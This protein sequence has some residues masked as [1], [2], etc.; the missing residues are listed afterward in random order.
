LTVV[1]PG[2]PNMN[3]NDLPEGTLE[4]REYEVSLNGESGSIALTLGKPDAD[5]ML[6]QFAR[7]VRAHAYGMVSILGLSGVPGRPAVWILSGTKV[8]VTMGDGEQAMSDDLRALVAQNLALF[9]TEIGPELARLR[10]QWEG[11]GDSP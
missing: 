2:W 11:R 9:F 8:G 10:F 5:T 1:D 3:D 6:G 4:Y 7:Y